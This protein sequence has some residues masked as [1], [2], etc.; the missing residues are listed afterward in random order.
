MGS[1]AAAPKSLPLAKHLL[2]QTSDLDEARERV[3]RVFCEYKLAYLR[4]RHNLK[5]ASALFDS[6]TWHS[7]T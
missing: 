2:V 4:P 1:I 3:A 5:H 6:A 7:A